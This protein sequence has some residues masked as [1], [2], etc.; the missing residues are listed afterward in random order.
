[1]DGEAAS[2]LVASLVREDQAL[3]LPDGLEE[4]AL[5]LPQQPADFEHILEPGAKAHGQRKVD[6]VVAEVLDIELLMQ[7]ALLGVDDAVPL[8]A[9]RLAGNRPA[10]R[11]RE[12][13]R[14]QLK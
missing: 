9:D 12:I 6:G 11:S 10:V 14:G 3:V 4:L 13:R 8:Q 1:M 2:D 7:D 5:D